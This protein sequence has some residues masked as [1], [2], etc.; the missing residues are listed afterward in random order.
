[1]SARAACKL[2][3]RFLPPPLQDWPR[4]PQSPLEWHETLRYQ[5]HDPTLVGNKLYESKHPAD[6]LRQ[7]PC[8]LFPGSSPL[9]VNLDSL[10]QH[11]NT[12]QHQ[13]Q[14][15]SSQG[16]LTPHHA[17][18]DSSR[19]TV[20]AALAP[21]AGRTWFQQLRL[22]MEE[23]AVDSA[24]WEVWVEEEDECRVCDVHAAQ[25]Q[26]HHFKRKL[27]LIEVSVCVCVAERMDFGRPSGKTSC[28]L[29]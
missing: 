16:D 28:S 1:M 13:S 12:L 22:V 25:V 14:Q 27:K 5:R 17:V 4:I 7:V 26:Q 15:I 20:Q 11:N 2:I 8:R 3:L 21:P 24:K 10:L 6:T 9:H 19:N 23:H 29:Q 18:L